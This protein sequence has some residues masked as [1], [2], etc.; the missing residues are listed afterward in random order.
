VGA[1]G[2]GKSSFLR[3]GLWPRLRRDDLAWLPIPVIRPERA[4]ISGKYGLAE[5]LFE[6]MSEPR[7]ADGVRQRGL[8]RSRADIRDFVETTGDGLA[9][10]LAALRDIAQAGWRSSDNAAPLTTLIAIDQG[11]E[12]FNEEGR[13]EARRFI[14]ILTKTL[15]ADPRTLALLAMRSDS[16]PL[17]QGEP[18]LAAL[19]KD[20]F[21][22]DMML[23]GS[24]RAVIEGPARL[25]EPPLKI[26][27]ELTDALLKDISGQDALPLLAF[28]LAHLYENYRAD[29][30]LT[31]SGYDKIGR[32]KGVID[33][34]VAQ[35]FAEA[36]A[37]NEAPKDAQAQLK[38]ARSA[39]I[40]HL[41][42]VNPAGE[43]VR[44]VS[45]REKIPP[46][47][48][49][50]IDRF[51]EQRLLVRD[52]R[53]DTEVIEVAHETVLRQP[54]FSDWLAEDR[55]FLL[56]RDRLTQTRTAFEAKQ[57]G[58]LVGLELEVA[59]DY[60][61]KRSEGE[62]ETADLA[63][64]RDSIAADDRRRAEEE[65]ERT[66]REAAEREEQER[67]IRDAE[68]RR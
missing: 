5:A 47:A 21:T 4:A 29:N 46:E 45:P 6:L 33:K 51:A 23:E 2:S 43:F 53:Q 38:L 48:R 31:L 67:R 63:F 22:I 9:R 65:E 68:R 42:Q 56:W 59:R 55:E 25:V 57:R 27:P 44:Y 8:P 36:V 50:L 24:Y 7:F 32:V 62:I 1:S 17:V 34:T 15:T 58:L 26:D 16:F 39:F 60:Q 18:R 41:A 3:A 40:P 10:L 37:K 49:P 11:E 28:T 64:I 14:E 30:E 12:L 13:D 35:A 61:S 52:R 20:T 54:P 66:K 19:P